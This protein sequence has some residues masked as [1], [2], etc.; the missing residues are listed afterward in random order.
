MQ[1]MHPARGVKMNEYIKLKESNCKNCYKCIRNC[2][3]KSIQFS[4]NQAQIVEDECILCGQCFVV[5]PQNAKEIRNDV[6]KAK[7]LIADHKEVIASIAPSFIANYDGVNIRSMRRA[8]QKLGFTAVEET[9]VGATLVKERYEE[10]IKEGEQDVIISSCCPTVD[11]L[12]QKHFPEAAPCLAPVLTPMQAHARFLKNEHPEA[13]VVFIGPCIS[14]KA[15]AD[16]MPGLVDC[17]LTYEELTD[18]L[19]QTEISFEN[20][21]EKTDESKARL[22]P[23]AGG[24]LRTMQRDSEE[25]RYVSIDGMDN[26]IS[27]IQDVINGRLSKCFIEMS[28]CAGSCVGGPAMEKEHRSPV[29]NYLAVDEYAGPIDFEIDFEDE[30]QLQRD[31]EEIVVRSEMPTESQIED[32]LR[33]IGKTKPEHELNC[34]CCGYNTCRE[35]AIAVFQGKA[36]LTMCLPFLKEKAE[37]FS[38]SIIGNT[39][40]G[41]IVLNED[42]EVQQINAAAQAIMNIQDATDVLGEPVIRILDPKNFNDVM[43]NIRP[44]QEELVYL[45]EYAK[46]VTQTIIFDDDYHILICI[47]RDVTEEESAREKKEHFNQQAVEVTDKVIEK[48]M[49]VVQEIASLLGE[50]TAETKV[51]LTKLKESLIDE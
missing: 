42:L 48:Q 18:W 22:F 36:D 43:D 51:A 46:Y 1:R 45:A 32:I 34:G 50:T 41:I 33:Q 31:Y 35:K 29:R 5:C 12:I 9:A 38:D 30:A 49:R 25:Y 19:E 11:L 40:N 15:E 16:Q 20:I 13:K 37:S 2:P 21:P 47:L 14:K 7:E 44:V 6:E 4:S 39:P 28:A 24:I 17:V 27:A 23:T 10:L 26:C 8:L 3:V